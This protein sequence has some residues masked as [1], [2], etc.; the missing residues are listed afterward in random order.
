MDATNSIFQ[1]KENC[2][3]ISENNLAQIFPDFYQELKRLAHN[4]LK[5]TWSIE[6]MQTTDLLHE[7]YL[8]LHDSF[9]HASINN[10]QH[11]F[12][13]CAK[14]MR[15]ILINY[16]EYKQAQKRGGNATRVT[17]TGKLQQADVYDNHSL[18]ILLDIDK[19][20]YKMEEIDR[21][22]V[23][24]VELKFFVG[25]TETELAEIYDVNERTIRRKWKKAK[26]L[27]ALALET[28][29]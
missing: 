3:E 5:K 12:L 4:Q 19:G 1:F 21:Q 16:S 13:L 29:I 22:L 7:A 18:D 24:L 27:L 2:S 17:Y 23:E 10:K 25:F 28:K 26:T 20:L 9:P 15:Q 8:K 14:A 11:F 6:T